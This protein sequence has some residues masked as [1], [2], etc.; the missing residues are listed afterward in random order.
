MSRIAR[1][2]SITPPDSLV[3]NANVTIAYKQVDSLKYNQYILVCTPTQM[4]I[5]NCW[6]LVYDILCID[7]NSIKWQWDSQKQEVSSQTDY[8]ILQMV[9]KKL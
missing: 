4:G 3:N 1:S 7:W 2:K 5:L 6:L 9:H 8:I